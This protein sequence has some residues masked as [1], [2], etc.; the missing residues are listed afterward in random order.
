VWEL[1]PQRPGLALKAWEQHSGT[2]AL[3]SQ[4][5]TAVLCPLISS[6]S[7]SVRQRLP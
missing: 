6:D 3:V 4:K 1:A 2:I 7:P 5:A